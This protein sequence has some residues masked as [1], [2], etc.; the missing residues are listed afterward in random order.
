MSYGHKFSPLEHYYYLRNP[1]IYFFTNYPPG[2][3]NNLRYDTDET[4]SQLLITS[5]DNYY[6]IKA[7]EKPRV[8]IDRGAYATQTLGID[9]S[10][11]N[12]AG[13]YENLGNNDA[14][15]MILYTGTSSIKIQ[16]RNQGTCDL[17]ADIVSHFYLWT[18]P[19]LAGSN[20]YKTFGQPGISVSSLMPTDTSQAGDGPTTFEV[21]ISIPWSKEELYVYSQDGV[22]MKNCFLSVNGTQQPIS[23]P[24]PDPEI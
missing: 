7:N 9:N 6:E 1:L 10:M 17:L 8:L 4:K 3:N 15:Y 12:S 21:V 16:A 13:P 18:A 2:R 23:Q 11:L 20:G 5:I 22:I 14:S 24:S 19:L